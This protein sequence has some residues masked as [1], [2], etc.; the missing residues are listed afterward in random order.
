[1]PEDRSPVRAVEVKRG[2][3]GTRRVEVTRPFNRSSAESWQKRRSVR[4]GMPRVLNMYSTAPWFRTYFEAIGIQK[5]NVVFTEPTTEEMWVEG[6]EQGSAHPVYHPNVADEC[7]NKLSL[8]G[9]PHP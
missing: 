9:H 1:M 8:H 2:I 6:G 5:Q 7:I 3:F 4:I